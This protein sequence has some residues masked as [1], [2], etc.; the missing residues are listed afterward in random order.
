MNGF[1]FAFMLIR[2]KKTKAA[3]RIKSQLA[4]LASGELLRR[5]RYDCKRLNS[6]SYAV[7]YFIKRIECF[8][9]K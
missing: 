1:F 6:F 2:L 9:R 4:V 5:L 7:M 3:V 8:K